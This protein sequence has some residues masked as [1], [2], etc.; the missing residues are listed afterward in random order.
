MTVRWHDGEEELGRGDVTLF[1]RGPDGLHAIENRTEEPV[2]F[3]LVS[4]MVDPDVT[5]QPERGMVGVFA[6]G[7]PTTGR[8]AELEAFFPRDAA[9]GWREGL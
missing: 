2:R 5:E 6:G 9:T 4:S 3:V 7:V 8:D 1:P